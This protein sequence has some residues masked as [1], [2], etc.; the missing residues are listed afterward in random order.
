MLLNLMLHRKVNLKLNP[1]LKQTLDFSVSCFGFR[2]LNEYV[3]SM[4]NYDYRIAIFSIGTVLGSIA[5]FIN[6]FM[7]I[8]GT[9]YVI[10][11]VLMAFEFYS[12]IRA[13]IVQGIP[14]SSKKWDRVLLKL[15]GYSIVLVALWEFSKLPDP[16]GAA[17]RWAHFVV[18]FHVIVGLVISVVENFSKIEGKKKSRLGVV[19][20]KILD[21]LMKL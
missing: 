17:F 8:T 10:F 2:S 9:M 7:G 20:K 1:M 21:K 13:S 4:L 19:L 5:A 16:A 14:I 3:K 12:G 11:T 18:L 15:G 6:E